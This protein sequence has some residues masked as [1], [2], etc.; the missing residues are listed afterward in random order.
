VKQ[1]LVKTD[2]Q[3]W[4]LRPGLGIV[5]AVL[6]V[7]GAT[8]VEPW[9][10]GEACKLLTLGA[11]VVLLAQVANAMMAGRALQADRAPRECLKR[12]FPRVQFG[13][14][15]LL[16]AVTVTAIGLGLSIWN[17]RDFESFAG[18]VCFYGFAFECIVVPTYGSMKVYYVWAAADLGLG[19][20]LATGLAMELEHVARRRRR[21]HESKEDRPDFL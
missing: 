10:L 16:V 7:I 6:G 4:H 8:C 17:R 3:F 14:G 2:G 13:L 21:G 18:E 15:A 5:L 12:P 11:M 19:V 20:A 9:Y 1:N